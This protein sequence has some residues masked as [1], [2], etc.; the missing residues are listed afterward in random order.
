MQQALHLSRDPQRRS[1]AWPAVQS[2]LTGSAIISKLLWPVRAEGAEARSRRRRFRADRLPELSAALTHGAGHYKT[3]RS[4]VIE[5]WGRVP[6]GANAPM[7][8]R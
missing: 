2:F 6:V 7:S 3:S 1:E 8:W 4:T 5:N